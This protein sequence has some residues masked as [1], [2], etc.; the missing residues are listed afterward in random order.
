MKNAFL[1]N[2]KSNSLPLRALGYY[3]PKR[4]DDIPTEFRKQ[5]QDVWDFK[6]GQR[7]EYFSSLVAGAI[8]NTYAPSTLKDTTFMVVPAS[9]KEKHFRRFQT[10][11]KQ[12][13]R[14]T[15]MENGF[16][17]IQPELD[18][19]PSKGY[20]NAKKYLD[21]TIN[22]KYKKELIKGK[23]IFLFDDV[24]TSG[25]S[26]YQNSKKLLELGAKSVEGI[27]LAKTYEGW[28]KRNSFERTVSALKIELPSNFVSK[29]L[30][31]LIELNKRIRERP[32]QG[33]F[34]NIGLLYHMLSDQHHAIENFTKTLKGGGKDKKDEA[35]VYAL[36]GSTYLDIENYNAS[37]MDFRQALKSNAFDQEQRSAIML[38]LGEA[39]FKMCDY[40]KAIENF[41]NSLNCK[42]DRSAFLLRGVAS[43]RLKD[44]HA[45]I[46]DLD[47]ALLMKKSA[48]AY[49]RRA[50]AHKANNNIKGAI[51]DYI[52]SLQINVSDQGLL[53]L[54][55]VYILDKQ[56]EKAVKVYSRMI[57]EYGQKKI[58]KK[59]DLV[60]VLIKRGHTYKKVKKYTLAQKDFKMA[61]KLEGT[62][63]NKK[64]VLDIERFME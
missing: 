42:D 8:S 11:C 30:E 18:R 29:P 63:R 25:D 9:T 17:A 31:S 38:W 55:S 5:S 24:I 58:K 62:E 45:A 26:F 33:M 39:Y 15:G 32:I 1:L 21:K 47:N 12:I 59:K 10:F 40:H 16:N 6:R 13:C 56:F 54:A 2:E 14:L 20:T 49:I 52:S 41:S 19:P 50:D 36:R 28:G 22:N 43:Y 7:Q 37:V 64:A 4:F 23:S 51:S 35:V 61:L 34:A 44:Y 48:S 3:Y 53:K 46:S 57:S 27:F 60:D